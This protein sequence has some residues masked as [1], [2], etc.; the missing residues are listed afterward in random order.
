ME[1]MTYLILDFVINETATAKELQYSFPISKEEGKQL[2]LL[3]N[4]MVH[5][6]LQFRDK[7]VQKSDETP[8]SGEDRFLL[9]KLS[10]AVCKFVTYMGGYLQQD[11]TAPVGNAEL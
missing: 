6:I 4:E 9:E 1:T 2:L 8:V 11:N 7:K 3:A 5:F 10:P